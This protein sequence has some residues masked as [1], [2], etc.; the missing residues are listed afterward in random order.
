MEH[1][2]ATKDRLT[3]EEYLQAHRI[4]KQIEER[5]RSR[6]K[7]KNKASQK[8]QEKGVN[9]FYHKLDHFLNDTK[10]SIQ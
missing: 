10:I 6:S 1:S 3:L 9:G 5:H 2:P 7:G 8:E 4:R